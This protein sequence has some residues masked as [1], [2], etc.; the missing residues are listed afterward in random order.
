MAGLLDFEDPG[1]RMGLGLL[2][3]GQM[4]KSQGLQGMVG[5]LQS[6]DQDEERK[7]MRD[8][9][10]AQVDELKRKGLADQRVQ[11]MVSGLFGQPQSASA[12]G[13]I[14]A[15]ADPTQVTPRQGG[16]ANATLDQITAIKAAGGPDLLEHYKLGQSGVKM[17]AGS[18]YM[19]DGNAVFAPKVGDGMTVDPRTGQVV[20][21]P[22][23]ANANAT[24]EGAKTGAVESAKYPYV[25]GANR[26][27]QNTSASLDAVKAWNPATQREEFVPRA[28]LVRPQSSFNGSGY[29][30]G[31][32]GSAAEEQRAIMQ[33]E[34]NKLPANHPDRAA[35]L[36]EMSRLPSGGGGGGFAAGPSAAESAKNEADRVRAT[37]TAKADV[38]RDT[39]KQA[40]AKRYGQLTAGI[41]RA[42]DLLGKN[43][44]ASG[45]GALVDKG[46][47]AVG[48]STPS[49]NIAS[50]LETLS[51]WLVANVPRMEGAQ[52]NMDVQNYQT[53]AGVVG[54]RSKPIADRLAAAK[55]VKRL[56]EKYAELNGGGAAPQQ[57][58]FSMLP[59]ASEFDGKRMRAPDGSIYRSTGGKWMKE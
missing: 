12:T 42:I 17:D 40:D 38:V 19:R 36:R 55:E 7:A 25:I 46:L 47:G 20:A 23:Y 15:T 22:G 29:S 18:Y 11:Q 43:P 6:M 39:T 57:R 26:D 51:G 14:G 10:Q 48:A 45:I 59:K 54:D 4:P 2:A 30:G 31:S 8:Y 33:A 32:S 34:L 1:M 21:L 35:I 50:Q 16:L 44:T 52:S 56:Q 5:L 28:Q 9:R 49:S 13:T 37:D 53:M 41:D 24:I 3:L 58:E 27:Q